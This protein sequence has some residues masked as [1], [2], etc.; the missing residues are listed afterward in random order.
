M[1]EPIHQEV[2][3]QA[4][5]ARI[6]EALLDAQQFSNFSGAKAEIDRD[7]GGHFSCF[8]G[9]ILGRTIEFVPN[10]R[11][12]QAWRV[13]NWPE[14]VYSIVKFEIKS[15]GEGTRLVLDQAGFPDAEREHL[16]GGWPVKYWT[17]LRDYLTK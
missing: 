8:G 4:P 13:F 14:G 17:P 11:I 9:A 15:D 1:A 12:V 5:A 7:A 3:I 10:Q 2:T 16:D 6:F